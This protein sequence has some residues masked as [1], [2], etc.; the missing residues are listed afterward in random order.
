MKKVMVFG[1]FDLVH[2]G[3][4]YFLSEARRHGDE[5]VVVIARDDTVRQVK[6]RKP[7]FNEYMRAREIERLPMTDKVVLG[8]HADRMAV[9]RSEAPHV[10]CLGYDQKAFVDLLEDLRASDE[11]AFEIVR[12]PAC[13]PEEYQSSRYRDSLIR[14]TIAEGL[15][16]GAK[17]G[18]PTANVD[19]D[20][21]SDLQPEEGVFAATAWLGRLVYP[22]IAIIGARE[23]DGRPLVELY[24]LNF[25]GN[26]YGQSIIA[27][28]EYKIRDI[29]YFEHTT[30]LV[31]RIK[32]DIEHVHRNRP[33][34]W[35]Y[36]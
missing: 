32:E 24:M 4:E 30:D 31:K 6:G 13:K 20:R 22:A 34:R 15:G 18:Y 27:A 1:T 16:I 35:D 17:M 9:I 21:T 28:L 23:E 3:H 14:G 12:L 26:L 5:L 19:Y 2:P 33:R 36:Q 29:E 10:V 7:V 25:S 8:E 11:L